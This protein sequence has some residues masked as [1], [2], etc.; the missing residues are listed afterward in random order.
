MLEV[1]YWC[2][3]YCICPPDLLLTQCREDLS[4]AEIMGSDQQPLTFISAVAAKCN[5]IQFI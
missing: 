2:I 5:L 1:I 3:S 4:C